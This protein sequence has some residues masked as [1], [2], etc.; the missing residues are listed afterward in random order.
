MTMIGLI[1]S[2]AD[3]S[4]AAGTLATV[5]AREGGGRRRTR[6]P[7]DTRQ[8]SAYRSCAEPRIYSTSNAK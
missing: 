6:M 8:S 5:F 1:S 7:P 4:R 3:R 2:C